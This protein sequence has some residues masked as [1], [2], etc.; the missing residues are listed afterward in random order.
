MTQEK[1]PFDEYHFTPTTY[2]QEGRPVADAPFTPKSDTKRHA[3]VVPPSKVIPVIFVPGI[4]GSNLKL[5]KLPDG[6]AE[7][8]YTTGAKAGWEW[9]PVQTTTDGWGDLAWR[10]DDTTGFMARR[11]WSLEAHERRRLLD[12]LNTV[13]DD[14]ADISSAV[15]TF[16]FESAADGRDRSQRGEQRK[17]GFINEM[18]RRGWGTVMVSSYGPF[19]AFLEKNLNQMYATGEL[20]EFWLEN[21]IQRRHFERVSRV[22]KREK[23]SD[24]GIVKGDKALTQDQVKK[25]STFWLPVH[26]VGYNWI[27]S[28]TDSAKHLASKITEFIAHYKKLGYECNKALLITHS[29]GGLVA[30][31]AVH[32]DIGGMTDKVVGVVHGVMPTHGAAA[33]YRRS[34]AGFEGAGISKD[35]VAADILGGNGPEVAAVFSNSPG[36]LQL[37]PSK[38]YGANWLQIHDGAGVTLMSLPK[39]DPYSEIYEQKDV[40]WRLMNP[41]WLDPRPDATETDQRRSW[42]LYRSNLASAQDFHAIVKADHHSHTHVQYGADTEKHKAFGTLIWKAQNASGGLTGNATTSVRFLDSPSGEVTLQDVGARSGRA[43]GNAKFELSSKEEPG[44]GTVPRRS[45]AAL[46]E[47]VELVAEHAGYDHQS[48]YQDKR[49]QELAAYSLVRLIAENMP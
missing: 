7:K 20:N 23:A 43:V 28:N 16:A 37:L 11:F 45:A 17:L 1:N 18:K 4:M 42:A 34:R 49:A 25:A 15:K 29:M 26:A 31:A 9:P 38:L 3:V 36:A 21:I 40:W 12:P 48:S 32:A 6:F 33:A 35:S 22:E 14:R 8:R 24:W 10:P 27:Q 19:L 47:A 41:A 13:V 39:A 30:R 5:K 46:N 44:D 2:D